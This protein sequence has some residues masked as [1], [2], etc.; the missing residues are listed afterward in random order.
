LVKRKSHAGDYSQKYLFF[1][2]V[3]FCDFSGSQ[4]E[5]CYLTGRLNPV[6]E[7]HRAEC[8]GVAGAGVV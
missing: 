3:E 6:A 5:H 8:L 1:F 2:S 4:A 7:V